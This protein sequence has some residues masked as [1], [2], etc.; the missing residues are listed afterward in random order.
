MAGNERWLQDADKVQREVYGLKPEG[1]EYI[2]EQ[3]LAAFIELGE[4]MEWLPWKAKRDGVSTAPR[5]RHQNIDYAKGELVDVLIFV[6]N[7]A[8]A[9]GFDDET[10]WE[11]VAHKVKVNVARREEADC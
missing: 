2:K 5:A 10:I 4:M 9:L 3:A 6:G 8:V 7:L 11:A 1:M